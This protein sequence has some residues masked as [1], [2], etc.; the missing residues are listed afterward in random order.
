MSSRLGR[1][2]AFGRVVGRVG[3]WAGDGDVRGT[4]SDF[5]LQRVGMRSR[6]S[7]VARLQA[8]VCKG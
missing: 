5:R 3:F 7:G 6:A 1:V 8:S 4:S 2:S